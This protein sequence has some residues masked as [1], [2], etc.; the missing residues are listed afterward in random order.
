MQS[1]DF[2]TPVFTVAEAA[3]VVSPTKMNVFY[4][5]LKNPV[6]ISV[7]GVSNDK[8]RVSIS[9]GH[10]IKKQADGSYVV[11][12]SS[13]NSNKIANISVK[14]EMPDG[15]ISD[16][17]RKEF[18]VKRIPDP[19]PFWSGKRPSNRTIS[20]NE[21][22][23]FAPLAAKMENFDFDVKVRVKSFTIRVSKD[24]TFKELTSGN[25]RLTNDMKALLERVR[26]GNTIYFEDI[27]VGLPDGTERILAPMK[28]KVT[29]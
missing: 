4:R 15:S 14:G 9:S 2:I 21:V 10:K 13:A 22:L 6:D 26:R 7:P 18:R 16:L 27:V 17:G 1:Q 25:N 5:G 29:S 3:L 23:S 11:E 19:V 12:P 28:L 24:G 8:L 20:K